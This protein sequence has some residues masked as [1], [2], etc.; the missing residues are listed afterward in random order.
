MATAIVNDELRLRDSISELLTKAHALAAITYGGA[1]EAFRNL[2]D[3][4]QDEYMWA[5]ADMIH[6]SKDAWEELESLRHPMA[7][8]G[9][10]P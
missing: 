2:N 3:A 8:S 9:E 7:R 1:G 10:K 6:Q 5:L 4:L